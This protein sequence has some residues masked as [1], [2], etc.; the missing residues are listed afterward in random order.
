MFGRA[1]FERRGRKDRSSQ[2]AR[3]RA[4]AGSPP[5]AG[6][7]VRAERRFRSVGVSSERL[8]LA[9]AS[10]PL[11]MAPLAGGCVRTRVRISRSAV[12]CTH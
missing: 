4:A 10:A 5:P 1:R 6:M 8:R 12:G 7:T 11:P 9:A 3:N 2:D